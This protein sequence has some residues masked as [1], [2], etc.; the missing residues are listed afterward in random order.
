MLFRS[1]ALLNRKGAAPKK[2]VLVNLGSTFALEGNV[3]Q[4]RRQFGLDGESLA[5]TIREELSYG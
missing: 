5:N 2:L 4:L 3:N 1:G